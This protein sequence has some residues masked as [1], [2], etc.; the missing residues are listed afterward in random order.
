MTLSKPGLLQGSHRFHIR[1]RTPRTCT[2][3]LISFLT[4]PT[5]LHPRCWRRPPGYGAVW[6]LPTYLAVEGFDPSWHTFIRA[7]VVTSHQTIVSAKVESSKDSCI[8]MPTVGKGYLTDINATI[9]NEGLTSENFT[10]TVYANSTALGTTAVNN[11]APG[12][13]ITITAATWNT[14]AW[15]TATTS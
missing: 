12:A 10:V 3:T 5:L 9:I 6:E 1:I 8:P 2:T 11:L 4:T 13:N 7:A 15:A 14:T